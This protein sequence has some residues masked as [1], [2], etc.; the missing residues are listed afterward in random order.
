MTFLSKLEPFI[1]PGFFRRSLVYVC[2]ACGVFAVLGLLVSA[3]LPAGAPAEETGAARG[4]GGASGLEPWETYKQA[5]TGGPL[6]GV[7]VI[8]EAAPV[9]SSIGEAVKNYR[10]K[11]VML[12]GEPE[13]I[14]QD[15]AAGRSV[16]VKAGDSLGV[17]T[18]KSIEEGKI[19][20][21]YSGEEKV[22]NIE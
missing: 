17:L 19:V 9:K 22:L 13:A 20:V 18:V 15:S 14:V 11:G 10:L 2:A 12:L 4:P 6:F 5:L 8:Q 7:P 1:D 16:F 3:A 21:Q